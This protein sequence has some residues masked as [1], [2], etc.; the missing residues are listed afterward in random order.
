MSTLR[1]QTES[2]AATYRRKVR[3]KI[4]SMRRLQND[5]RIT[6]DTWYRLQFEIEELANDLGIEVS[7]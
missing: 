2:E 5:R 4:A 3:R 6:L 1:T 7:V